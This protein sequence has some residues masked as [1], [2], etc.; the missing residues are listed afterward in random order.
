MPTFVDIENR[1]W[2]VAV[3]VASI[4]RVKELLGEDLLDWQPILERLLIDPIL[5]VDV[6]YVI[7]KPQADVL[8]L[9]DEQ[10]AEAMAGDTIARAKQALV[11]GLIDFFPDAKDRENARI[12]IQKFD[13]LTDKARDLIK[14]R[15]QSKSLSQEIEAALARVGDSFGS[16]PEFLVSPP[17]PLP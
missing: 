3:N 9:T 16:S 5:L 15:L 11:E 2:N 14:A 1:T 7:C 8:E 13:R 6:I 10:F 4:K 12:A 17:G